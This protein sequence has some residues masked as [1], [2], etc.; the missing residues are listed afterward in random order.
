MEYDG[1]ITYE[2]IREESGSFEPGS[3]YYVCASNDGSEY[4][5]YTGPLDYPQAE[6]DAHRVARALNETQ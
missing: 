5:A 6:L 2:V 4:I 3:G 1:P